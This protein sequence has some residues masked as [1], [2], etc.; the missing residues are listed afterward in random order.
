LPR[1]KNAFG[2]IIIIIFCWGNKWKPYFILLYFIFGKKWISLKRNLSSTTG[3]F[4][5]VKLMIFRDI[6]F[7]EETREEKRKKQ[8]SK[9]KAAAGSKQASKQAR[10][11]AGSEGGSEG[12]T[13][14]GWGREG[15]KEKK[16]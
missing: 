3:N 4:Q 11:G 10:K 8:I 13:W 2:I 15:R 9:G 12:R 5:N 16:K 7:F 6:F 1:R 14:E